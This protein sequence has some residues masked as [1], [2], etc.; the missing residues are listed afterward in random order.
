L[1]AVEHVAEFGDD[2]GAQAAKKKE[3]EDRN[4]GSKTERSARLAYATRRQ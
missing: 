2:L 1:A 3:K 4:I